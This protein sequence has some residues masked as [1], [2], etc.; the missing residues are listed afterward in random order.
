[1]A[2]AYSPLR[3]TKEDPAAIF[4]TV[5]LYQMNSMH[6]MHASI[7][8]TPCRA[9]APTDPEDR[10]ISLSEADVSKAFNQVN[11]RKAAGPDAIPG[12]ILR[13]CAYRLAGIFMVIFNLSLPHSVIPRRS[14]LTII[15]P[16]PK[17]SKASC[18]NDY[19]PVALTSVFM[20]CTHQ[21]RHPRQ[22]R[23]TPNLHTVSW[24]T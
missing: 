14:K 3:S 5:P 17:N 9:W 2:G 16:V 24:T 23:H 8:T 15:N 4:S 13:E 10:G 11:T 22:S 12:H 7:R 19:Y 1:M 6:L 20:K 18:H 21:L